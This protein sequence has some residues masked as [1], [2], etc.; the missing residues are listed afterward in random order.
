M[1]IFRIPNSKFVG[2]AIVI[3]DDPDKPY[4]IWSLIETESELTALKRVFSGETFYVALFNEADVNVSTA[5]TKISEKPQKLGFLFDEEIQYGKEGEWK[6]HED[7]AS[8]IFEKIRSREVYNEDNIY[9][10]KSTVC[11]WKEISSLYITSQL[12]TCELNILSSE[13][14]GQQEQL[15]QWLTDS[16]HVEGTYLNPQVKESAKER[17]LCDLFV[18]YVGGCFLFESKALAVLTREEL[19]NRSKLKKSVS[20]HFN[21]AFKQ[22]VGACKNIKRNLVITNKEG[23]ELEINREISPHCVVLVPDMTL[24]EE[25]ENISA[26]ELTRFSE[27]V[28]AYLNVLDP[29]ELIGMVLNAQYLAQRSENVTPIM[30]FDVLLLER[31]KLAI[32]QSNVSVRLRIQV[33]E[34]I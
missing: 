32:A 31:Y 11:D 6:E 26:L 9:M 28:G 25:G 1:S 20:K 24:L 29:A 8:S 34:V 5:H 17:E 16:L 23:Q 14:G 4:A 27:S 15:A 30:A 18:S 3:D 12:S 21:K 10:R 19:P 7:A 33:P 22:L 13:E 2:Y